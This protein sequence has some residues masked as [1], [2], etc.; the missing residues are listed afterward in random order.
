M[1]VVKVVEL[2]VQVAVAWIR[3]AWLVRFASVL[4]VLSLVLVVVFV[5]VILWTLFL[6]HFSGIQAL[7][8]QVT[9]K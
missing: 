5:S 2:L 3:C 7:I 9:V 1:D 6:V 4:G 8:N